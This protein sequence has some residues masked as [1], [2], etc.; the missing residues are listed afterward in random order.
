MLWFQSF[1]TADKTI[2]GYE[3][4]HMLRK[5]QVKNLAKG[6]VIAEI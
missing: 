2:A 3:T 1:D 4:M 5:R 6:N